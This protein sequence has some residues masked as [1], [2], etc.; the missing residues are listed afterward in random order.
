MLEKHANRNGEYQKT[1]TGVYQGSSD[2]L[3]SDKSSW[4]VGPTLTSRGLRTYVG[5]S[6]LQHST[7]EFWL[8]WFL[9]SSHLSWVH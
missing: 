6:Y 1:S 8:D 4:A 9:G 3:Y 7:D 2:L 5:L